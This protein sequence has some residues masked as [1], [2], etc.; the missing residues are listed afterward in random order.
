MHITCVISLVKLDKAD[1]VSVE[2]HMQRGDFEV[3]FKMLGDAELAKKTSLLKKKNLGG[4]DLRKNLRNIVEQRYLYLAK[5]AGQ[6][7]PT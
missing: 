5:L 7:V 3:W 4:E 1:I 6:T 2:F